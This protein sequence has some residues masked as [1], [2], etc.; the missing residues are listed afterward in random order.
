MIGRPSGDRPSVV[1]DARLGIVD[2]RQAGD[3]SAGYLAAKRVMDV[4]LATAGLIMTA[5]LWPV[6]AGLLKLEDGGPVFFSQTRVGKG[7]K[8]FEAYKFRSMAPRGPGDHV[9]AGAGQEEHRI[10]R[11]GRMLRATALDELPQLLN[12]LKGDMSLVGPRALLPAEEMTPGD[13]VRHLREVRGF[14]ERHAVRPG[15]TGLAQ[16][17]APRDLPHHKKFRYDLL[18]IRRRSIALDLFLVAR[19]VWISLRGAWPSV[20]GTRGS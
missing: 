10:T 20:G 1:E 11:V 7:G 15:L 17:R 14:D 12:V 19:S 4:V 6:I 18:Y 8:H 2:S 13:G 5:P 9:P 16:V 3:S